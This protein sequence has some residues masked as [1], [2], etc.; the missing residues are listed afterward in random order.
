[1]YSKADKEQIHKWWRA[2]EVAGGEG[3]RRRRR[4]AEREAGLSLVTTVSKT[5]EELVTK[6]ENN[7]QQLKNV[8]QNQLR[9]PV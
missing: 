2:E 7:L 6:M 5:N 9:N 1:M 4:Q 3:G 8:L